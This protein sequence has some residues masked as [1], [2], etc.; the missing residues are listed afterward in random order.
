M[1]SAMISN[2]NV[3]NRRKLHQVCVRKQLLVPARLQ[4]MSKL[5]LII[6]VVTMKLLGCM[7]SASATFGCVYVK[8]HV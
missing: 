8:I 3:K 1:S 2:G 6:M 4:T 7:M 5:S